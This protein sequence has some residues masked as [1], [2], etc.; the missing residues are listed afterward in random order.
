MS[1]CV[2]TVIT[3]WSLMAKM[4]SFVLPMKTNS[5]INRWWDCFLQKVPH[6]ISLLWSSPPY[7]PDIIKRL[8]SL[9]SG[10]AYF[11]AHSRRRKLRAISIVRDHNHKSEWDCTLFAPSVLDQWN[12]FADAYLTSTA[13]SVLCFPV[14]MQFRK[15]KKLY[16]VIMLFL[17]NTHIC[18]LLAVRNV[19]LNMRKFQTL[20]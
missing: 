16:G 2:Q 19:S 1:T 9:Q 7:S 4:S 17:V 15:W 10:H 18:G 8:K 11:L 3:F 13:G 20:S 6:D 14:R 12:R 5:R